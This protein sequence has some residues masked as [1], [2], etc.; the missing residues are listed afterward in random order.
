VLVVRMIE[1]A[2]CLANHPCRRVSVRS[3]EQVG[4]EPV[5]AREEQD[6]DHWRN[7]G[8]SISGQ[9]RDSRLLTS[10]KSVMD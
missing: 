10:H 7:T 2:D 5:R 1:R 8:V 9:H 3:A 4:P 6:F